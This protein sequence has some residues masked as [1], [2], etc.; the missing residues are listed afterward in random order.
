VVNWFKALI[1]I[2]D[3]DDKLVEI[4]GLMSEPEAVMWVDRLK[5][6]GIGAVVQNRGLPPYTSSMSDNYTV[7]TT[8]LHADRAREVMRN[9]DAE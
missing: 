2:V 9:D 7:W 1:G 8:A 6:E 3:D 5:D 4:T